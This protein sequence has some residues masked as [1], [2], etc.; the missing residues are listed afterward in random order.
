MAVL[1][2]V[3]TPLHVVDAPIPCLLAHL[4]D[5]WL[6]FLGRDLFPLFVLLLKALVGRILLVFG[7]VLLVTLGF[8]LLG[9]SVVL[10]YVLVLA[11]EL[12]EEFL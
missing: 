11:F 2:L 9:L 10:V 7:L 1:W 5:P 3:Y 8:L 4:F 12:V 6:T